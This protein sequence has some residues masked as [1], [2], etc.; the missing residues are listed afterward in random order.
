MMLSRRSFL[1]GS[2]VLLS[3]VHVSSRVKWVDRLRRP[4]VSELGTRWRVGP[5]RLADGSADVRWGVETV[6]EE[7]CYRMSGRVSEAAP[8]GVARMTLDL[9]Q[10]GRPLDASDFRALRLRVRGNGEAY[11]VHLRTSDNVAPWD[12]YAATFVASPEWR[13]ID[14]PFAMFERARRRGDV[15]PKR[16]LQL[17]VVGLERD[18]AADVCVSA[19]GLVEA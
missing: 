4:G 8:R 6:R 5:E 12:H 3:G 14:F 11:G 10:G 16:L 13:D 1:A 7:R 17:A 15:D 9:A 2:V 19:V 18:L